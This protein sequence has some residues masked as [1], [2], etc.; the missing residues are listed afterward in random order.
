MIKTGNDS[1]LQAQLREPAPRQPI[2]L[3]GTGALFKAVFLF[4]LI[5][6]DSVSCAVRV[7]AQRIPQDARRSLQ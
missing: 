5:V 4:L 2:R 3:R 1:V 6:H 7:A